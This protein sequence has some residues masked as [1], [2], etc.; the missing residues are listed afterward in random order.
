MT[1]RPRN[2]FLNQPAYITGRRWDLLT[3]NSA[4]HDLF[5][6]AA[7]EDGE[8]NL[9]AYMFLDPRARRLFGDDWPAVAQR[10]LAQFRP[11]FDL[12][13]GDHAFLDLIGHLRNH[14]PE[15]AAWWENHDIRPVT[16]GQKYLHHLTG[17]RYRYEHATFQASDNPALKLAVFTLVNLG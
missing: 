7:E 13:A 9:L 15:C 16:S 12:W 10:M 14:S 4:A 5:G 17:E 8:H 2:S 3:W 1:R 11:T 6:F